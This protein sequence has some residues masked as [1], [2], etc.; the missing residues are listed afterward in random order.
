MAPKVGYQYTLARTTLALDV[1]P[2]KQEFLKNTSY[3]PLSSLGFMVDGGAVLC[4]V[5][6]P[7]IRSVVP[8]DS[9]VLFSLPA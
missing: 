7:V 2:L 4:T 9:K 8:V 6:T 1:Q 5:V 3:K